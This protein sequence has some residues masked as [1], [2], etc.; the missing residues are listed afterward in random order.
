MVYGYKADIQLE[1]LIANKQNASGTLTV[2]KQLRV[3]VSNLND[4][5]AST[6][7]EYTAFFILDAN[8][9]AK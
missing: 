1:A 8:F 3:A 2:T 5:F 4:S 9:V 7:K 6:L